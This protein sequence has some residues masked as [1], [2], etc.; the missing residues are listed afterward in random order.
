MNR[1]IFSIGKRQ[2]GKPLTLI[3][4]TLVNDTLEVREW[5]T[6]YYMG[7]KPGWY[8]I[9]PS[10]VVPNFQGNVV[11]ED[12]LKV[13]ATPPPLPKEKTE[14]AVSQDEVKLEFL[15][16]VVDTTLEFIETTIENVFEIDLEN[17]NIDNGE[18]DIENIDF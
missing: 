8:R 6:N 13:L 11:E 9:P 4:A 17:M 1:I 15:E 12:I 10:R 7:E 16:N 18:I 14:I 3:H 5:R 2:K